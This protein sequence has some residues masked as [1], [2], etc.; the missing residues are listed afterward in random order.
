VNTDVYIDCKASL[1][2]A[3]VKVIVHN[4]NT[5]WTEE[6]AVTP[7]EAW[8]DT[9]E[10]YFYKDRVNVLRVGAQPAVVSLGPAG[11][12]DTALDISWI[13]GDSGSATLTALR[14][15]FRVQ[16][17]DAWSVADPAPG[18]ADTSYH[19]S[20][21][22]GATTYEVRVVKVTSLGD[23]TSA[24]LVEATEQVPSIV[25]KLNGDMPS[26]LDVDQIILKDESGVLVPFTAVVNTALRLHM[27]TDPDVFN[28]ME[29]PYHP[30]NIPR[31][32][33]GNGKWHNRLIWT[34]RTYDLFNDALFPSPVA[35]DT[36]LT[37]TPTSPVKS[38]EV[39]WY[40]GRSAD[41]L[42]EYKDASYPI[43]K[44]QLTT[45]IVPVDEGYTVDEVYTVPG[46]YTWIAPNDEYV[47]VELQGGNGGDYNTSTLKG[48]AF[49]HI[50]IT[51]YL[52]AGEEYTIV[53]G[54]KGEPRIHS[55]YGSS[56]RHG[57][58]GGGGSGFKLSTSTA[59]ITFFHIYK[60]CD[61]LQVVLVT[62]YLPYIE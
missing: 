7:V 32:L 55:S 8:L 31:T 13:P 56:T 24:T 60:Y 16:G 37:L 29:Y 12:S 47:T 51:A 25:M 4:S 10:V 9:F 18:L 36:L 62:S 59:N 40:R 33:D 19:L 35:G 27:D 14:L 54:N 43:P 3:I 22:E 28:I 5:L 49:G 34:T 20:S 38:V 39:V 44:D 41:L 61:L 52:T 57:G 26:L 21:L 2:T 46:T 48:G 1:L 11:K 30:I 45:T 50:S 15:E 42:V 23:V 17:V 6:V 53:V 58:G